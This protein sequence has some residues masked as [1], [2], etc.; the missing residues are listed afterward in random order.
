MVSLLAILRC[1]GI[2]FSLTDPPVHICL[3]VP[4]N[5]MH[6]LILIL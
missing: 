3:T 1:F 2:A 4:G 6:S 5:L